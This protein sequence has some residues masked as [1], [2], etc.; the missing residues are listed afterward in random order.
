MTAQQAHMAA[1]I[2]SFLHDCEAQNYCD[3][4]DALGLLEAAARVLRGRRFPYRGHPKACGG[5][6]VYRHS[7]GVAIALEGVDNTVYLTPGLARAVAA[8]FE[9]FAQDIEN[10]DFSSSTLEANRTH[11]VNGVE[12]EEAVL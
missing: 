1:G 12:T 4:G 8:R 3:S 6:V 2:D 11:D 7:D 5:A 10:I 9:E